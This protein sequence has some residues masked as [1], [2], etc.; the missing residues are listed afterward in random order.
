MPLAGRVV[1]VTLKNL[2][3]LGFLSALVHPFVKVDVKLSKEYTS[4]GAR[5]EMPLPLCLA[6]TVEN[7]QTESRRCPPRPDLVRE[8]PSGNIVW[9]NSIA[10]RRRQDVPHF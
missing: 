8:P 5:N 3:G 6:K 9:Q 2:V 7:G 10:A 4:T 1:G